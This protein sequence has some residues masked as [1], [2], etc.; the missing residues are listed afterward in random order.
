M[1]PYTIIKHRTGSLGLRLCGLGPRFIPCRGIRQIQQL[2][3]ENTT[4]AKNR[5]IKN[6]KKMLEKSDAVISLWRERRIIGFGRATTDEIYRATLWDVVIKKEE[7]GSGLGKIIINALLTSNQLKNVERVYLM[8]SNSMSFYRQ[9]G[10][11]QVKHQ[12]LMLIKK[13][14]Y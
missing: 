3:E 6:I 2:F 5:S 7:Q 8:T 13:S 11:K 14:D 4:W 1:K 12:T 10:F 9:C